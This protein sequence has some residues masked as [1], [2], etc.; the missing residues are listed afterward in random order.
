MMRMGP[1][2]STKLLETSKEKG[3]SVGKAV[4]TMESARLVKGT[5]GFTDDQEMSNQHYAAFLFSTYAHAKIVSI[6]VSKAQKLDGVS[7]V[8]TGAD[9]KQITN[10]MLSRAAPKS[11]T[12]HYLMAV[13]KVRYMGEPVAAVVAKSKY[14]AADAVDL[15]DVKYE[16]LEPVT[17]INGAVAKDAPLIYPELGTNELITDHFVF[18]DVESAFK[19]AYKVVKERIKVER[20][21]STPLETFAVNAFFDVTRDEL[22]VYATDQQPSRTVQ[23]VEQTIGIPASKIRLVIPPT[24]GGFGYKLAIWQYVA[25]ISL[26]SKLSGVPVKWIQ[27]RTES[28]YAF[29]RPRGYMDAE[30]ALSKEGKVLGMRFDDWES[31]ANWPYVAGLYSLLKF[32]IM[33]GTYDIKNYSFEFHSIATNDPPIVQDRGVG[34]PL[35]SLVLERMMD[36][37]ARELGMDRVKIREINT[38]PAEM[39]PYK[40]SSG[41]IYESGDYPEALR[42]ALKHANYDEMVRLR[43]KYREEGR[44]VGIGI[45]T[46]IEPGSGN[47]GYYFLSKGLPPDYNGAGQMAT[48]EIAFDGVLKVK[49]AAPEIGTGH[50]T[51]IA[52]VV[53]DLFGISPEEVNVDASFDSSIGHLTYAGTYGNNFND[54]CIGAVFTAAKRLREKG[55]KIASHL[56][57]EDQDSIYFSDSHVCK[58]EDGVEKKLMSM[59]DLAKMSYGRLASLL[60]VEEPGLKIVASYVNPMG[61]PFV[62]EEFTTK[63]NTVSQTHSNAVHICLLEV[64]PESWNVKILDYAILHDAGNVINKGIVDGL[65]IGSTVS[66]IGAALYEEFVMDEAGNNLAVTFG[67]YLKPTAM[68]SPEIRLDQMKTPHPHTVLGTKAAGEGGA[69][70]SLGAVAGGVE[71]ALEPFKV[72]ITELPITPEKIWK[73]VKNTEKYREITGGNF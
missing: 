14:I 21:S 60:D 61:K 25:L 51:T 6:D 17:S 70:T 18:G 49:M 52:Q 12:S 4:T 28:L 30:F 2:D 46:G 39:M 63:G 27:T 50:V 37:S 15:I 48:V 42:R 58:T 41:E 59:R 71:D 9:I 62:R 73:I 1:S 54:V 55:L 57:E 40:S 53:S 67:E 34:K 19:S 35:M 47:T 66:G 64:D 7:L 31:D 22:L 26:M 36:L 13:D 44:L 32:T 72:R 68:E 5:A 38:I 43:N 23:S 65:V 16:R 45:A 29:H 33:T 24:G 69:I 10:P 8:L 3:G 20:Y 56:L 11:P